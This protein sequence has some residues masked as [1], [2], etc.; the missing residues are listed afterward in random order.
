MLAAAR[1]P[2]TRH[3]QLS[4]YSSEKTGETTLMV[5]VVNYPWFPKSVASSSR[6]PTTVLGE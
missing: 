6:G 1:I 5:Q 3:F 2:P 4:I